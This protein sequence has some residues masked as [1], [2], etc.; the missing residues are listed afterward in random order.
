M[1]TSQHVSGVQ[2]TRTGTPNGNDH[3]AKR[4]AASSRSKGTGVLLIVALFGALV[5]VALGIYGRVHTATGRPLALLIGFTGMTPMKAWLATAAAVLAI[6]QLLSAA[7]MWGRL[8]GAGPAPSWVPQA[9]RWLGAIAF[10]MT[11]P[12]AYHCLWSLGYS[13]F[14]LRTSVHSAAG[15]AFYGAFAT[16]MLALRVRSVPSWSLPILGG[17]LFTLLIAAWATA[18][19]WYFTQPGVPLL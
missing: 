3:M 19:L 6:T 1:R 13:T 2:R 14:D 9:H 7:W 10:L 18:S 8:P 16:K 11:L 5:A 12:V 17:L 4:H 15:C